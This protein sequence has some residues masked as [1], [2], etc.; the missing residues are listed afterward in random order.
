MNDARAM[1]DQLMGKTRDLPDHLKN[2]IKEIN[3]FDRQVC[4][5]YLCGLCPHILFNATKSDIGECQYEIC[6]KLDML[7]YCYDI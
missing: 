2:S 3:F 6:G 5:K 7:S 4:K 1:L